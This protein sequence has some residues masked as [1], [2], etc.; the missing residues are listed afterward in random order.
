MKF[1][2]FCNYW[3]RRSAYHVT[4]IDIV[5]SFFG[6]KWVICIVH[7][8]WIVMLVQTF[9][10]QHKLL[11]TK[12]YCVIAIIWWE[13]LQIIRIKSV[14]FDFWLVFVGPKFSE[15]HLSSVVCLFSSDNS[16]FWTHYRNYKAVHLLKLSVF[17]CWFSSQVSA[18]CIVLDGY[19]LT[20]IA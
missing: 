14:L 1:S 17:A 5:Y 10:V 6:S 2:K 7:S 19:F 4:S 18:L 16:Y 12:L 8:R 11:N 13:I 20:C 15:K 9:I 3:F